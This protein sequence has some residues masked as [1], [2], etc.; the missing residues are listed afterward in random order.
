MKHRLERNV[1]RCF[2]GPS[3]RVINDLSKLKKQKVLT[4]KW[5]LP[6]RLARLTFKSRK[7]MN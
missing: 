2:R 1:K 4:R 6:Q 5:P 3:K 7:F